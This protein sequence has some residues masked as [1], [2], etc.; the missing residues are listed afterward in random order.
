LFSSSKTIKNDMGQTVFLP[1][2]VAEF[3]PVHYRKVQQ[4]E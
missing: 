2:T 4:Y 3:R 1:Q